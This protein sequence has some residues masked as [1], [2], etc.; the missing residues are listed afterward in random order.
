MVSAGPMP[1]S[2]PMAVPSAE[3]MKAQI[4]LIGC[5]ATPK[6]W[7]R[8]T[9]RVHEAPKSRSAAEEGKRIAEPDAE[10]EKPR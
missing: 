10:R 8:E 9:E 6:P 5:S 2:T 1:G 4:R 3:P 7:M